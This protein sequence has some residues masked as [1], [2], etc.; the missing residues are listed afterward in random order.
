MLKRDNFGKKNKIIVSFD[1]Y[2]YN[3]RLNDKTTYYFP[4]TKRS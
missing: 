1:N 3:E 4:E 2:T